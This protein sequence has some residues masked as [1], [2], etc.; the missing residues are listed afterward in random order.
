V[1]FCPK[2]GVGKSLSLCF[3]NVD[4][5]YACIGSVL[6]I[7]GQLDWPIPLKFYL[8]ISGLFVFFI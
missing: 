5:M 1:N 3:S 6:C 2:F 8:L 7:I 4:G